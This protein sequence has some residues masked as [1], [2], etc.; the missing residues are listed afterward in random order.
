[1][2]RSFGLIFMTFWAFACNS[3]QSP[4]KELLNQNDTSPT[5]LYE[6]DTL[7]N[8]G[9]R[10][11]PYYS[12]TKFDT[13]S[14]KLDFFDTIPETISSPG[15]FYTFDTTELKGSKYI[16]L[17]NRVE[18]AILKIKGRDIYLKKDYE[19]SIELS[20]NTFKEVFAGNGYSVIFIHKNIK[21]NNGATYETGTL[22]ITNSNHQT[23]I[24]IHGGYKF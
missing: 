9:V 24:K 17:T 15:D 2:T 4:P 20:E 14:I 13:S 8:G 5:E 12:L 21:H 19:K 1:M 3:D 23:L 7:P 6:R 11:R 16:F 10:L 18:Y 22:D